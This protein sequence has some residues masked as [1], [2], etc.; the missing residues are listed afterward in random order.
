[1]KIVCWPPFHLVLHVIVALVV[2]G[3]YDFCSCAVSCQAE[4]KSSEPTVP[5]RSR[6]SPH[7]KLFDDRVLA[8][9]VMAVRQRISKLPEAERFDALLRWVWPS[10]THSSIR[11]TGLFTQTD[12]APVGQS[13]RGGA[14]IRGGILVSPVF[15]L[16]EVATATGRL[17]ELLT[18]VEALPEPALEEQRRARAAL[19]VLIH[20]EQGNPEA[21]AAEA[22]RL[23]QW[24]QQSPSRTLAE[25]WPQTLVVHRGA[26]HV[27]VDDL[28]T[29]LF[30]H[31]GQ[32]DESPSLWAWQNQLASLAGRRGAGDALR[33]DSQIEPPGI[34][35]WTGVSRLRAT[36]R[37]PGLPQP[38]W[39]QQPGR[40]TKTSGHDEDYL[41]FR[42]PLQGDYELDC[43]LASSQSQSMVGGTVLGNDGTVGL[44]RG[45]LRNGPRRHSLTTPLSGAG[46]WVHYR[47][48]VHDGEVKHYLNGLLVSTEQLGPHPDPW[49]AVRSWSRVHGAVR[50]L[51]VVGHPTIP[52]NV[53]LSAA[54]DLRGWFPYH[55]ELAGAA[56]S[57]WEYRPEPESAA[58]ECTGWIVGHRMGMSDVYFESLLCYQRPLDD[59]G[60]VDYEFFYKP[61]VLEAHPTLDRLALI[62]RPE[63]VR[64]H[65]VTDGRFDTSEVAPD[66]LLDEPVNQRG[67]AQLPLKPD[68]WNQ[69]TLAVN[70]PQ[71]S[72]TLNG[73]LVY[74]R[75]LEPHNR[76][77]FGLFHDADQSE[78]RVRNV[79]L[80][81]N[82]P[83]T[84]P[85]IAEQELA[86]PVVAK[87]DADLPK[88]SSVLIHDFATDGLPAKYFSTADS[89][90]RGKLTVRPD[91]VLL[92]R[93]GGGDWLDRNIRVPISLHGDFDVEV[94]FQQLKLQ[95]DKD[96]C[97]MLVIE[98]QDEQ[99]HQCRL[100][101]IRTAAQLQQVQ[102][103]L[104]VIHPG[105]ARSF[106]AASIQES[107]ALRG[108][109]RLARRGTVVYYLYAEND[110][111]T[112]RLIGTE[113]V[114]DKPTIADGL[115]LHA[116]CHG[117][118]ETQVVWKSLTLRAARM[119]FKSD[120]IHKSP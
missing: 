11:T 104:S 115:L 51:R 31:R 97:V 66:N 36:T 68:A 24:V 88:L 65:W 45:D 95:S 46:A 22:S 40:I 43:D 117:N 119:T 18:L 71:V 67:P 81:G 112:F 76:R 2:I 33:G 20:L 30:T 35:Q 49:V 13:P 38:Q 109:L 41:F 53:I 64:V 14:D 60:S 9:N 16:L 80:Q 111:P 56:G 63:G 34:T 100:L 96:A 69:V 87:L 93:P 79:V 107:E 106:S 85:L 110:S 26:G 12:P 1:M 10:D 89:D 47:G 105:G 90:L 59:V 39:G 32:A 113:P 8:D 3:L 91:G 5:L 108:R 50:D 15:D 57:H 75:T 77:T 4:S 72:L 74:E 86:D 28:L 48:A 94:A 42:S 102:A 61:G 99:Q 6:T 58:P 29:W 23:F 7:A 114:S 55:E 44:W 101:R 52:N 70:G 83:Q 19:L 82:W 98:L 62:L 54:S 120:S 37:G 17:E 25:I 73:Q 21:A 118:G 84:L 27:A 78:V 92:V 103:S 116:L